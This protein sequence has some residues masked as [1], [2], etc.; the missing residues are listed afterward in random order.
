MSGEVAHVVLFTPKATVS[1][2]ER[3]AFLE[4]LETAFDAVPDIRRARVGR[5]LAS[6]RPY[7]Q[8]G[9]P[10]EYIAILEFDSAA[11]LRRYLEHPAH[12][13]ARPRL[14]PHAGSGAGR[15]LRPGRRRARAAGVRDLRA[16]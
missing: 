14:L 6:D 11:A 13:A 15:R 1:P 8:L 12:E 9:T 3:A 4:A 2:D 16:V 5:R 7:E 10:F